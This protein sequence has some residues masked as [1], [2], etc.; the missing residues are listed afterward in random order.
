MTLEPEAPLVAAGAELVVDYD[1]GELR[2]SLERELSVLEA[3]LA[4]SA[5]AAAFGPEILSLLLSRLG[6]VRSRATGK[7]RVVVIGD[8]KRGK[9]TLVNA[10]LGA[11]V[12]PSDALPETITINEFGYGETPRMFLRLEGGARAALQPGDLESARL[13]PLLERAGGRVTHVEVRAPLPLLRDMHLVDTPGTGDLRSDL[14]QQVRSYIAEADVLLAV[15]AVEAPLSQSE[16][17]L[18]RTAV[19]PHEFPRIAFVLNMVDRVPQP[20]DV[21]RITRHVQAKVAGVFPG[22]RV[23]PLSALDEL[24]RLTGGAR[25]VPEAAASLAAS[26]AEFRAELEQLLA[27]RAQAIV[28]ER[29]TYLAERAFTEIELRIGML[30]DALGRRVSALDDGLAAQ[31]A[32]GSARD[33]AHDQEQRALRERVAALGEVA[34]DWL[35]AF[36]ERMAA[37]L[38]GQLQAC[39]MTDIEREFQFFVSDRLREAMAACFEAHESELAAIARAAVGSRTDF[40]FGG[41]ESLE[42]DVASQVSTGPCTSDLA[43]VQQVL[44]LGIGIGTLIDLA[45]L[46]FD[47]ARRADELQAFG[48]RFAESALVLQGKVRA[49]ARDAYARVADQLSE[50]INAAYGEQRDAGLSALSRARELKDQTAAE[51]RATSDELGEALQAVRRVRAKVQQLRAGAAMSA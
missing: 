37:Q 38:A 49:L 25:P 35:S 11:Q 47:R 4:S 22:A 20:A 45:E 42:R 34:G 6:E 21:E 29:T 40:A 41:S 16:Q 17:A 3:R 27:T 31:A 43:V 50:R 12:A 9:S 46:G 51:T 23:Y 5:S 15:V 44:R 36:I 2:A 1:P 10:L 18:L 8:F 24:M 33:Q 26:F 39:T 30:Q 7:L 28:L 32:D 14:E 13:T 48:R 19:A